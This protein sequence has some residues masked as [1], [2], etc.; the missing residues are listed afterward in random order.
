[1]LKLIRKEL[2]TFNK[3]FASHE[4]VKKFQLVPKEWTIEGGE[5]TATM[6]LKRKK[7]M[8]KYG[9]LVARIYA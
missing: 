5:L 7:I 4:Q 1:V 6:K 2:D 3:L 8:E 9:E